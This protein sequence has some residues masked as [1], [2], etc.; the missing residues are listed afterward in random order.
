M[1]VSLDIF[2][3]TGQISWRRIF[4]S[5]TWLAASWERVIGRK[6]KVKG[7]EFFS[8]SCTD[9]TLSS[10]FQ[11]GMLALI[12]ARC[13]LV[14]R[15]VVSFPDGKLLALCLAWGEYLGIYMPLKERIDPPILGPSC[16][17]LSEILMPQFLT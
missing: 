6:L 17:P 15:A 16:I 2:F 3:W 12:S 8:T 1:S 13:L 11:C 14:Q 4:Q 5:P 7:G 9:F 10:S